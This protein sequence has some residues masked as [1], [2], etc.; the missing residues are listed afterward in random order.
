MRIGLAWLRDQSHD[1]V[2]GGG[3]L[4]LRGKLALLSSQISSA[5]ASVELIM[6]LLAFAVFCR[7]PD[8]LATVC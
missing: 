3:V 7:V 8:I 4:L 2:A 5:V 1:A 6:A